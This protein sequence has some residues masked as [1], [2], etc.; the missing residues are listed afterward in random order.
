DVY[1]PKQTG[2][3]RPV[4]VF[5][6]GGSFTSGNRAEYRFV[7]ASLAEAGIVAM[8]PDYRLYPEVKFPTFMDDAASAVAWAQSHA[9]EYGGDPHRVVLMGHSAG[10]YI[11]A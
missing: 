6:Y 7:G 11:A 10:A 5:W 8:L 1:Q 9:S 4:V 3:N 2:T